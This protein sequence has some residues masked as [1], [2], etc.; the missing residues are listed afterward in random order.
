MFGPL[1]SIYDHA[2]TGCG[3]GLTITNQIVKKMK[4]DIFIDSE[5]NNGTVVTVQIPFEAIDEIENC[6]EEEFSLPRIYS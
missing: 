5:V 1:S 6:D 3:L 2:K 4:G